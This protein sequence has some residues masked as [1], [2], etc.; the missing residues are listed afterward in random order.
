[1]VLRTKA[2]IEYLED[3]QTEARYELDIEK[4]EI[5]DARV[6]GYFTDEY[7]TRKQFVRWDFA[8]G[9]FHKDCLYEKKPKKQFMKHLSLKECF[10]RAK[11]DLRLNW[12]DYRKTY[13][14]NHQN[15]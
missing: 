14:K 7:G 12:K 4:G 13:I 2:W 15:D 11:E 5:I 9:E 3:S 6:I 8:H 1:M 10:N